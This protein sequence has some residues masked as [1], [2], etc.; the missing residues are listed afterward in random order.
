[1]LVKKTETKQESP[2]H[3]GQFKVA[4]TKRRLGFG[5]ESIVRKHVSPK[6][7]FAI[8]A[9]VS[10]CCTCTAQAFPQFVPHTNR[11]KHFK[12]SLRAQIITVDW[13]MI[14]PTAVDL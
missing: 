6:T 9:P 12:I 10:L 4:G 3:L 5:S 1:M 14:N 11:P 2:N 7:C 8:E 13:K